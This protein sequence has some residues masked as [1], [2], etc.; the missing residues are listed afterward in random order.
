M[1]ERPHTK[2][3]PGLFLLGLPL[4]FSSPS[5]SQTADASVPNFPHKAM[6]HKQEQISLACRKGKL[7]AEINLQMLEFH[8]KDLIGG[9][10]LIS[11]TSPFPHLSAPFS[12][13]PS[14]AGCCWGPRQSDVGHGREVGSTLENHSPVCLQVC[15][16]SWT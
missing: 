13:F 15:P 10:G 9:E 16:S 1:G 5:S 14:K 12:F 3:K 8:R 4:N 2:L 11:G 6:T 7:L